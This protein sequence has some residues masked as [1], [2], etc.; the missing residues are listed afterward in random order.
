MGGHSVGYIH[1]LQRWENVH[2]L[3][4]VFIYENFVLTCQPETL[5]FNKS[6]ASLTSEAINRRAGRINNLAGQS[7]ACLHADYHIKRISGPTTVCPIR[8]QTI[9]CNIYKGKRCSQ[10][11]KGSRLASR[12]LIDLT[13]ADHL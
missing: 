9:S 7:A 12:F 6:Q 8:I 4:A 13:R 2:D 10:S 1:T 3:F 5:G 11:L